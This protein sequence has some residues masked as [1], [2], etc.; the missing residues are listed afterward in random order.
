MPSSSA[1][2]LL[3]PSFL[4]PRSS[5]CAFA[6]DRTERTR[7]K[8]RCNAETCLFAGGWAVV[9]FGDSGGLDLAG[10]GS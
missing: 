3:I 6:F 4:A 8:G 7:R 2:L 9:A 5:S 1:A 10:M